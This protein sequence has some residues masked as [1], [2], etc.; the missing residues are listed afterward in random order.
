MDVPCFLYQVFAHAV[1]SFWNILPLNLYMA[2]SILIICILAQMLQVKGF[3]KPSFYEGEP[4]YWVDPTP[5]PYYVLYICFIDLSS[6][7]FLLILRM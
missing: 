4:E 5:N 2:G 6:L 3:E 7:Y 1:P